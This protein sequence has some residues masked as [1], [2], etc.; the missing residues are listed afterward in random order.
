MK[1]AKGWY[2][3]LSIAAGEKT[4]ARARV[5]NG[6]LAVPTYSPQV[7]VAANACTPQEGTNRVYY[8][9][10]Y[11]GAVFYDFESS[12]STYQ[13][14]GVLTETQ[15]SIGY[16]PNYLFGDDATSLITPGPQGAGEAIPVSGS[17]IWRRTYW[18]EK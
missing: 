10:V 17:N 11:S 8:L 9:D 13:N 4:V 18:Y 1:A 14:T 6:E 15:G 12:N 5:L 3:S 7:S 2:M 16:T